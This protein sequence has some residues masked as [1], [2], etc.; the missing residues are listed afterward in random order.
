MFESALPR[1][2]FTLTEKIRARPVLAE[3]MGMTGPN[4]MGRNETKWDV[5]EK[6]PFVAQA[7]A[8]GN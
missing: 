8:A 4:K 2:P 3:G 1:G 6:F 7:K 5:F